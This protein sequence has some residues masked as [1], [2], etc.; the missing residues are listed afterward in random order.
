MGGYCVRRRYAAVFGVPGTTS[1]AK[2]MRIAGG[3]SGE[4]RV[5]IVLTIG[6]TQEKPPC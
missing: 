3:T 1:K 2:L 5:P 6:T 4:G